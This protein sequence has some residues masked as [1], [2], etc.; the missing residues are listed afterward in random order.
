ME[1]IFEP[2]GP[3]TT[4]AVM[5]S[6]DA[7][8]DAIAEENMEVERLIAEAKKACSNLSPGARL[9]EIRQIT[10]NTALSLGPDVKKIQ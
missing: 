3:A 9:D 7:A 2:R 10:R 6:Q 1:D 5:T 4:A 8:R